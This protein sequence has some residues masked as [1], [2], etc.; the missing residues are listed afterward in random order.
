[1]RQAFIIA[2]QYLIDAADFSAL[3]RALEAGDIEAAMRALNIR[4]SSLRA[5]DL[6][7]M[8]AFEAGG[9]A[10]LVVLPPL[11]TR[12]GVRISMNFDIRHPA[13]EQRLQNHITR[14]IQGFTE[15]AEKTARQFLSEG[16]AAGRNPRQTAR[17]LLG[18][19]NRVTGKREGGILKLAANQ[20]QWVD[21]ARKEL[22]SGNASAL[23]RYLQR[24]AR[25]KRFDKTVRKAIESGKP[26]KA[27]QIYKLVNRYS[28]RLLKS[29]AEIIAR[30]ETIEALNSSKLAAYAQMA[31]ETGT[32]EHLAVK[33]WIAARDERTRAQH[34]AM[35]GVEVIGLG[36]PFTMPDGSVMLHPCDSSLGAGAGQIINCRC[37]YSVR[38]NYQGMM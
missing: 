31:E 16:L 18:P 11:K 38:L 3:I 26:L 24:S 37:T 17:D 27:D 19:I 15:E 1:M 7:I 10:A 6:A 22:E 21:N 33:R 23:N 20:A 35:N 8:G 36:T 32:G 28:D 14:R 9:I 5:V 29:R 12:A 2:A 4:T 13:A 25:D 30:T 34:A